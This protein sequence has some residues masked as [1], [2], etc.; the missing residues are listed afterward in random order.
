MNTEFEKLKAI[1]ADV[2]NAV[3]SRRIIIND[4]EEEVQIGR[5]YP[6]VSEVCAIRRN[7]FR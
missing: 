1:I 3:D 4:L 6:L 2:L 7:L 5:R